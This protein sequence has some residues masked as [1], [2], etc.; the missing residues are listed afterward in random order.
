VEIAEQHQQTSQNRGCGLAVEL[1]VD[2]GFKQRF[3]GRMIALEAQ[4]VGAGALNQASQFWIGRSQFPECKRSVVSN[5][6]SSIDH[7]I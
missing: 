3:K 6:S 1:L 7:E 5:R 4:R 2:D